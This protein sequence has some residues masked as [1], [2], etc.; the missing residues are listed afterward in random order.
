MLTGSGQPKDLLGI[1][2]ALANSYKFRHLY[3]AILS[4]IY[5]LKLANENEC[6][7]KR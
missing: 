7:D 5:F 6:L 1:T 3:E 4:L 2:Q